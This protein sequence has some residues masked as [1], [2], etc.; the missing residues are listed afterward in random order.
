MEGFFSIILREVRDYDMK[1]IKGKVFG[2]IYFGCAVVSIVFGAM[3]FDQAT[4]YGLG[5]EGLGVAVV[6]S[7]AVSFSMAPLYFLLLWELFKMEGGEGTLIC[8]TILGWI[9]QILWAITLFS[10]TKDPYYV[11]PLFPSIGI[12]LTPFVIVF[13]ILVLYFMVMGKSPE[14]GKSEER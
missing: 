4:H 10:F 14:E 5:L 6:F 9:C 11:P 1:G 8:S 13:G 12:I 7:G 3:A 2:A